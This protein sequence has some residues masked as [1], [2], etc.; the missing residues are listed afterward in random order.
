M[1]S[2]GRLRLE[3]KEDVGSKSSGNEKSRK[4]PSGERCHSTVKQTPN[5]HR[6]ITDHVNKPSML[7][8]RGRSNTTGMNHL[9]PGSNGT[10]IPKGTEGVQVD[11]PS[12]AMNVHL[13]N[14]RS[15]GFSKSLK[16]RASK[17]LRRQESSS[18]LTS[19]G[20]VDWSE[21][22]DESPYECQSTQPVSPQR[23]IRHE[24][25]ASPSDGMQGP[26]LL[27]AL[28]VTYQSQ[29]E[30]PIRLQISEPF[31]FQHLTHTEHRE[32][33]KMQEAPSKDFV[34]E[35]S[36]MRAS[37]VPR[38]ELRGIKAET[39]SQPNLPYKYS[40]SMPQ[41][42]C[43]SHPSTPRRPSDGSS[44]RSLRSSIPGASQ[45][46]SSPADTIRFQTLH[47]EKNDELLDQA[48]PRQL[49]QYMPP[50]PS[51][52]SNPRIDITVNG[53]KPNDI[54]TANLNNTDYDLSIPHAVTTPD[55]VAHILKPPTL[56]MMKTELSRVVEEDEH[57]D[58]RRNSSMSLL[59]RQSSTDPS[60]RHVKSFPNAIQ[61]LKQARI[62]T[63]EAYRESVYSSPKKQRSF[64]KFIQPSFDDA[65]P[66]LPYQARQSRFCATIA[67]DTDGSWEDLIDWCY[68]HAAEADCNFDFA[69]AVSLTQDRTTKEPL[70]VSTG[71]APSNLNHKQRSDPP[72]AENTGKR[73]SSIYSTSPQSLHPLQISVPELEPHSAISTQS[74][75]DSASEAV[76][77]DQ[78]AVILPSQFPIS[79]VAQKCSM[80]TEHQSPHISNDTTPAAMYE[81][82]CQETH[83]PEP[84]HYGRPEG[85]IIS[86]TSSRSSRS[87]LSKCSSQ[88]S[89]WIRRHRNTNSQGSLPDLLPPR[90]SRERPEQT[91][92]QIAEH[93]AALGTDD[94]SSPRRSPNSLVKDVAQKKLL[95]RMRSGSIE[96]ATNAEVP[97]PLHPALRG[98]L[99]AT[100]KDTTEYFAPL[101]PAFA[102]STATR[103]R[104]ASSAANLK[105]DNDSPQASRASYGLYPYNGRR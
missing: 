18:N 104:S 4:F 15:G 53:P 50:D 95:S 101:Q 20:G 76:T 98:N 33:E 7:Q 73:S 35:F 99:N 93:L 32:F 14:D 77:P 44:T 88:D 72:S 86:S 97:L 52:D 56:E 74:S 31:N 23:S 45:H 25:G 92:D 26:R 69:R 47:T 91:P 10:Y 103:M 78:S 29:A 68:D 70:V 89:S 55:N 90:L 22:L 57:S 79:S 46:T 64:F 5:H 100:P 94:L 1:L 75:F 48:M 54:P 65:T 8:P 85:S 24:Q 58:G 59:R 87:P 17:L 61:T 102:R 16:T 63:S 83:A 39:I 34:S 21:E 27:S 38:R 60:L 82:L 81:T 96:D 80:F 37:Q 13:R 19:L 42:P 105:S 12:I 51:Y 71:F 41:S 62:R 67:K 28:S 84:W 9:P 11:R 40:P 36:A 66:D 49:T 6:T 43:C 30:A 3:P 2:P